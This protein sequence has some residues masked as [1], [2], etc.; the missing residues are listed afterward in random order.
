MKNEFD[1]YTEED[2]LRAQNNFLDIIAESFDDDLDADGSR[3]SL[4][5]E[6]LNERLIK[7]DDFDGLVK[8]FDVVSSKQ[9]L[10]NKELEEINGSQTNPEIEHI[11]DEIERYQKINIGLLS[12]MLALR[13]DTL[14]S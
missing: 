14:R 7:S 11:F 5:L 10:L 3:Y 1:N 12:M 13:S 2:V 9:E 4:A 6:Y 8:A